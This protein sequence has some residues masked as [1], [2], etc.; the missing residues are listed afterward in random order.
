LLL[1]HGAEVNAL[2]RN[3]KSALTWAISNGHV[4]FA[5]LLLEKGAD[6]YIEDM[7]GNKLRFYAEQSG[8]YEAGKLLDEAPAIHERYKRR[9]AELQAA[10]EKAEAD[11]LHAEWLRE[12]SCSQG[13]VK[14]LSVPSPLKLK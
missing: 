7:N 13:L 2:D 12:T 14:P 6:P 4:K 8:V 10:R 11:L 3:C 1:G 5:R 9:Q